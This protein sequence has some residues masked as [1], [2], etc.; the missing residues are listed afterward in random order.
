[1]DSGA[2]EPRGSLS[3]RG[4]CSVQWV[5]LSGEGV[6]K[7]LDVMGTRHV[8]QSSAGNGYNR[9]RAPR[10]KALVCFKDIDYLHVGETGLFIHSQ[11]LPGAHTGLTFLHGDSAVGHLGSMSSQIGNRRRGGRR[12]AGRM[13]L[14]RRKQF[15]KSSCH[16]RSVYRRENRNGFI[17]LWREF[18]SPL[19]VLTRQKGS[20]SRLPFPKVVL[21]LFCFPN[22]KVLSINREPTRQEFYLLK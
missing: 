21:L 12:R 9:A 1:M 18:T 2:S 5:C 14:A 10:S 13:I 20:G 4:A 3:V 16:S 6:K 8:H 15:L 11:L 22:N 19:T 7:P 17:L